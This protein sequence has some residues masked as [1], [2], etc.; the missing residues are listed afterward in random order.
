MC[1]GRIAAEC[2]CARA[3]TRRKEPPRHAT[4]AGTTAGGSFSAHCA[5][6]RGE[7]APASDTI[8]TGSPVQVGIHS[9]AA[10]DEPAAVVTAD[11]HEEWC[12]ALRDAR[13]NVGLL[14]TTLTPLIAT[15]GDTDA[16][17]RY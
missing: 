11:E 10:C 4:G 16:E 6:T 1:G 3:G 13:A 17:D 15:I 5:P 9:A 7:S 12:R 14:A 2:R 8:T